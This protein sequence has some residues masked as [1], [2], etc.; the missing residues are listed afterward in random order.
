MTKP[1]AFAAAALFATGLPASGADQSPNSPEKP[2]RGLLNEWMEKEPPYLSA[3]DVGGQFRIRYEAKE[4]AGSFPNRDFIEHGQVNSNDYLLLRE[5]FHVGYTPQPWVTVYAEARDSRAFSDERDPSPDQDALDLH[6]AFL[7]LGDPKNFPFCVKVGRQEMSY[8]DERFVGIS[9][10]SNTRRVFDAAKFH[11]D[12]RHLWLD[13]F[14]GRVIIPYDAAFN[15]ANDYDW[16]WGLYASSG[17]L[18]PQLEA[19]LY[20][21]GRNVGDQSPQ[22]ITPTVGGPSAREIY[23][24]G[25]RVRSLPGQ[26]TGWDYVAEITG[27]FGR[28]NAPG[29]RLNHRALAA[30]VVAGYTWEMARSQPRLSAGYTYGSGDSDPEDG[31]NETFDLLFGTNHKLYG[32]M[33]LFGLRNIHSPSFSFSFNP[34]PRLTL[35]AD[36]LLFWLAN[37]HDY[38][39]PESSSARSGNGYGRN[40]TFNPFVGSELDIV[41]TYQPLNWAEMQLGYGHFFAGD[42]LQQSVESIPANGSV[43]DADWAYVQLKLSF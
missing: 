8:G 20:F 12:N 40:P 27:Q 24:P 5:M 31:V 14:A 42:Y 22:A 3:W 38:A 25:V 6:Q 34:L 9:D 43:T 4:N 28:I 35:R 23:T 16:F 26:W 7:A 41:A 32:L 39:Y 1:L 13:A 11:F 21:F 15:V 36:Y 18:I 37:T 10:W 19:Q 30:D 2:W 29:D 17:T 33:D